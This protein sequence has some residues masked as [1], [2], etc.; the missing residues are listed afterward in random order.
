[1]NDKHHTQLE[2]TSSYQVENR[3]FIVH[4]SFST[5]HTVSQL[6][7]TELTVGLLKNGALN[8]TPDDRII[9]S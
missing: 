2:T 4:R 9:E 3:R 8:N 7:A 5:Q 1:M 6:L